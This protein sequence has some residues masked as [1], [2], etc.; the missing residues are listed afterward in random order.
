MSAKALDN[1]PGIKQRNKTKNTGS[2]FAGG[3]P[4]GARK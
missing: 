3:E 4:Q 2:G 1:D